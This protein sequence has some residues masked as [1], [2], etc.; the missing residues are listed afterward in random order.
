MSEKPKGPSKAMKPDGSA[1]PAIPHHVVR[2]QRR[3]GRRLPTAHYVRKAVADQFRRPGRDAGRRVCGD[4]RP[5][6]R[7]TLSYPTEVEGMEFIVDQLE[8]GA[9]IAGGDQWRM[10]QNLRHL[11]VA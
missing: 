7:Y 3:R 10:E 8:A 2:R 11:W 6:R 9:T 5:L 1:G 4:H